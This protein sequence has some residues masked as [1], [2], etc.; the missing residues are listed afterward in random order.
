MTCLG[1]GSL[2]GVGPECELCP[3]G[4]ASGLHTV[5]ASGQGEG[6]RVSESPIAALGRHVGEA[7]H[8]QPPGEQV[9]EGGG[10]RDP[11]LAGHLAGTWPGTSS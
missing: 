7:T 6:R 3:A 10:Q 2:Q 5:R 1:P 4:P 11:S 8:G 9:V